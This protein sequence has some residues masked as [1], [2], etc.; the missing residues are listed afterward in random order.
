MDA[1][2]DAY[3][4]VS[5]IILNWN[6]RPFLADCLNA[7]QAQD[8][9][10]F[11]IILVDN[12]S[13]DD[14]VSF[15]RKQFPDVVVRVNERNTGFSAGNNIALREINSDLAV[16]LNPDV[17]VTADWL[18][19]LVEPFRADPTIGVA[20]CKLLYPDGMTLNHVGGYIRPP[21][22]MPGH[23]GS[24]E[25]DQGQH[26]TLRDVEYVIGAAMAVRREILS[27]TG[28]FDEGYFLYYEDV[29][30]CFTARQAGFRVVI[31][32]Q[33]V[34]THVESAVSV[35]GSFS[36]LRHFHFGRWRFLLKHFPPEMIVAE[37]L[38]AEQAWI[39]TISDWERLAAA[40]A[41][42]AVSLSMPQLWRGQTTVGADD[43][44]AVRQKIQGEFQTLQNLA[45]ELPMQSLSAATLEQQSQIEQLRFTS[46]LP[47]VGPLL[48][49]L[50]TTAYSWYIRPLVDRQNDYNKR[51]AR[52]LAAQ[53]TLLQQQA[54]LLRELATAE[55]Q[56]QQEITQLRQVI[57]RQNT[58]AG[59]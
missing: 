6:G 54:L 7:L 15:V 36:Y 58:K 42:E 55:A 22:A 53:E 31:V 5:V 13:T 59:G 21:Q 12:A 38:P 25:T 46:S 11:A 2:P 34:A 37:T 27:H 51:V 47:L 23:I 50:L 49:R 43:S 28:L 32:P 10:H 48:T 17:V 35:K 8:Y 44:P 40:Q 52:Q 45:W 4:T 19:Q 9:P 18:R 56:H 1:Y 16:L 20:G 57:G 41:Y 14:S 24:K 29:D 3:P 33:A 39:T 26:D 30:F